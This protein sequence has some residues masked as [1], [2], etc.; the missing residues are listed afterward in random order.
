MPEV[1]AEDLKDLGVTSCPPSQR[2]LHSYHRA[3]TLRERLV[4]KHPRVAAPAKD[5]AAE[6]RQVTA[7]T[8]KTFARESTYQKCVAETLQSVGGFVA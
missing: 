8:P 3:G 5:T 1:T 2:G 7:W 4:E 6:P